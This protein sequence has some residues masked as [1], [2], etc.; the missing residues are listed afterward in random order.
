MLEKVFRKEFCED[1]ELWAEI[2]MK[3]KSQHAKMRFPLQ[4]KEQGVQMPWKEKDP[5]TWGINDTVEGA[6]CGEQGKEE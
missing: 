5:C 3:W 6:V 1:V 4:A 2:W